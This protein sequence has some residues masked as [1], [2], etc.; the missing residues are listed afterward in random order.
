MAL[1]VCTWF[2]MLYTF[3]GL[4]FLLLLLLCIPVICLGFLLFQKRRTK[5]DISGI[6]DY[7]TRGETVRL[8][9]TVTENSSLPLAGT[10]IKGT[11]KAY[12]KKNLRFREMLEG[13]CGRTER[14]IE[15][16]LPAEHCGPARFTLSR[17]RIYDCLG[18]FS[19]SVSGKKSKK[20]LIT[21]RLEALPE[22]EA[23]AVMALLRRPGSSEEG[24]PFVREYRPGDSPRSIHWKL[25]VKADEIQVRDIE[26]DRQVRLFLNLT[27]RVW[28]APAQRDVLL[29]RACSLM[30]FFAEVCGDR[31]EIC[32]VQEGVLCRNP[33]R[34]PADIYPCIHKLVSLKRPGAEALSE[35]DMGSM[36]AGFH[37]EE[38]GRLYLK[39]QCIDEK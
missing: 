8:R 7:V 22:N 33:I 20:V 27:D 16:E 6:P 15:L 19:F 13:L 3:Q 17:A 25:T 9:V 10:E 32:W 5:V 21:P 38:D 4:R 12:G 28:G 23:E 35:Q 1:A 14:D 30:A 26:P 2:V 37:L 36:L 39:E 11:W 34:E 24:E 18:L 31:T 29:D